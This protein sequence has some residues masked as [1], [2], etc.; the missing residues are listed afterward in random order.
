MEKVLES[1]SIYHSDPTEL[2]ERRE[3][4]E[5]RQRAH[6]IAKLPEFL[7][8]AKLRLEPNDRQEVIWGYLQAIRL[9]RTMCRR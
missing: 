3:R 4:R 9:A 2:M 8:A 1:S 7:W 6:E 5:Q